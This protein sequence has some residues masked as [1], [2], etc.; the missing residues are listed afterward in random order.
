VG[1]PRSRSD[2]VPALSVHEFLYGAEQTKIVGYYR[3]HVVADSAV[4]IKAGRSVFGEYKYFGKFVYDVPTYNL[5]LP[6]S[7]PAST[8][9]WTFSPHISGGR[10]YDDID[11]V[12]ANFTLTMKLSEM[13]PRVQSSQTALTDYSMWSAFDTAQVDPAQTPV[14]PIGTQLNGSHRNYLG[15]LVTY[16]IDYRAVANIDLTYGD[17]EDGLG[18]TEHMKT[19]LTDTPSPVAAAYIRS[20]PAVIESPAYFADKI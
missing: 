15:A 13:Q 16:F 14:P 3:L 8:L 12:G 17:N 9:D 6:D 2:A 19:L 7:T 20:E 11:K 10:V 5:T 18:L 4:A 1:N